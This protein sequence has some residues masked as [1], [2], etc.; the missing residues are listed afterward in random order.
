MGTVLSS[1]PT[2]MSGPSSSKGMRTRHQSGSK[3][4]ELMGPGKEFIQSEVPTLRAVIQQ[5]ILIK[6]ELLVRQDKK[7]IH[8]SEVAVKVKCKVLS[9]C[10]NP[11]YKYQAKGGKVVEEGGG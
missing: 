3:L 1:T 4:T 11:R 8:V 5:G 2:K 10:N 7:D 9:T 6:E